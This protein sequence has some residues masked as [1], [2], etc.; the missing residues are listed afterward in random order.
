MPGFAVFVGKSA[1]DGDKKAIVLL[2]GVV[3]A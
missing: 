1:V 2:E 3:V